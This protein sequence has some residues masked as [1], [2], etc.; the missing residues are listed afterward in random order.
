MG[1]T[2]SV[3]S[4]NLLN[5]NEPDTAMYNDPSGWSKAQYQKKIDW[6][7]SQIGRLNADIIGFQELWNEKSLVAALVACNARDKYDLVVPPNTNGGR[8][9]CSAIVR[10]GL[11][12]DKPEWIQDFPK[13]V[14]LE[15][16]GEDPQTP[17]I[18]VQIKGF[19]RPVLHMVVQPEESVPSIHF[20]VCH[21]KSKAPTAIFAEKWYKADP[22]TY[23]DHTTCI[24]SAI[25]TIR[26]TA[27]A[28][29]LRVILN[30][31]MKGTSIP[32]IVIGDF[33]DN[34]YSNTSDVVTSQPR[35]LVGDSFGGGD[36]ALYSTQTLQEYRDSR[37]VYYT[38][39]HEGFRESLDQ[40]FV[41]QEFYD[42]SKKRLW[43][44]DELIVNND[45]LNSHDHNEDGTN[46]HGTIR[47]SFSW[48]PYVS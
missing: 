21:L 15:S 39:V 16:D 29:A 3:A 11:L 38:Y 2:F 9:V 43:M 48:R 47:A 27:E 17:E 13:A 31:L 42:H 7:A 6:T 33:N 10:K 34:T 41:S 45:H 30:G 1:K 37:D 25:S 20:F 24:G 14:R 23:K 26:R 19:S 5:L 36:A 46:D 28:T 18:Q 35:Y 32:V 8:I 12:R 44:F 4:F 40:I 22:T